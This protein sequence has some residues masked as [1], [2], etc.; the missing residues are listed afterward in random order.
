MSLKRP[1]KMSA[2]RI[3]NVADS[4]RLHLRVPS[5]ATKLAGV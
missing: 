3:V 5:T 1:V 2:S 4:R